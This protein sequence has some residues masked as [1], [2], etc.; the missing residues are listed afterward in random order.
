MNRRLL[1]YLLLAG[2]LLGG[3]SITLEAP[4]ALRLPV[5]LAVLLLVPG[6]SF[7]PL[8][9]LSQKGYEFTLAVALSLLLEAMVTTVL[10]EL[11][12]YSLELSLELLGS[13]SLIGCGLQIWW[14]AAEDQN[15]PLEHQLD[16]EADELEWA[17]Q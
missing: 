2:L 14:P 6:M 12:W 10:V 7:V 11:Q 5:M 9:R 16:E 15:D 4:Q 3:L 8:L 1:P 13:L 17:A